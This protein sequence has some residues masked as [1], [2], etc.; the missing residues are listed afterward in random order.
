MATRRPFPPRV[1]RELDKSSYLWIRAGTR[2]RFI[3]IWHVMVDGRVFVRSWTL[4]PEGWH[5]TFQKA[6][7][8]AIRLS[9][10]AVRIRAVRTRSERLLRAVDRAYREK[11]TSPSAGQYVRGM[12]RGRRRAS[13]TELVPG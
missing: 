4:E 13:T 6:P 2:H 1:L 10:R 12:S 7:H 11:Y 9:G 8:G 3:G 5:R